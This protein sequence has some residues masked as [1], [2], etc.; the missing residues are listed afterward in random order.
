MDYWIWKF[1]WSAW[2][3]CRGECRGGRKK[4][5]AK[6]RVQTDFNSYE[7]GLLKKRKKNCFGRKESFVSKEEVRVKVRNWLCEKKRREVVLSF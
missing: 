6:I 5:V 2:K 3:I 1:F 7:I 4:G